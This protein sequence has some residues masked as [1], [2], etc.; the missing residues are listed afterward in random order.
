[1]GF[2]NTTSCEILFRYVWVTQ[3]S[4]HLGRWKAGLLSCLVSFYVWVTQE[5]AP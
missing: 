5:S 3:E 1:M 4:A 2:W